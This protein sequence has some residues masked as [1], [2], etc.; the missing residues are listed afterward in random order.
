MTPATCAVLGID[1]GVRGGVALLQPDGKTI[2]AQGLKPEMTEDDVTRI[3][4][5]AVGLAHYARCH[6]VCYMEKVGYIRGDGGLGAF[7][8]GRIYGLLRGI[9]RCRSVPIHDVYPQMW[10][11]KLDCLSGGNKNVTKL[12]AQTLFPDLEHITHATADA[13]LIAYYGWGAMGGRR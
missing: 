13:L 9:L 5:E 11:A 3:V 1:P 4:G 8:F 7:T 6:L 10:Q 2:L 12:K